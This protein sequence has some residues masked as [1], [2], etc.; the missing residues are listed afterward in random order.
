MAIRIFIKKS[1]VM[2][3]ANCQLLVIP[4][5]PIPQNPD[6]TSHVDVFSISYSVL[7]RKSAQTKRK[8][9]AISTCES[10]HSHTDISRQLY[11]SPVHSNVGIYL[12]PVY[13][14]DFVFA[15]ICFRH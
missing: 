3:V 15:F 2:I 9:V 13:E 11:K 10:A 1:D 12:I 6:S 7:T 4:A 14:G 8:R 5:T